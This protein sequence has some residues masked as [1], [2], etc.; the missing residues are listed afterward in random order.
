MDN[1][2]EDAGHLLPIETELVVQDPA[3]RDGRQPPW[4]AWVT[5]VLVVVVAV[6]A[7]FV[8]RAVSGKS[9]SA[10]ASTNDVGDGAVAQPGG[11]TGNGVAGQR[12]S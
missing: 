1:D 7:F 12:E 9:S 5:G 3:G 8:T 11:A 2:F 10:S 6:G 4:V